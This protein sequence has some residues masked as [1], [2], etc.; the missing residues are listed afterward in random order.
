MADD[1]CGAAEEAV[2]TAVEAVTVPFPVSTALSTADV[3]ES[4]VA[5]ELELLSVC[6]VC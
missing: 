1:D 5:I 4:T 6:V 2:G 3:M